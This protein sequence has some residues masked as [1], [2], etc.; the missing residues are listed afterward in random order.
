MHRYRR[1]T[2]LTILCIIAVFTLSC[3]GGNKKTVEKEQ[4]IVTKGGEDY[5]KVPNPLYSVWRGQ[6]EYVYV[7]KS[8]YSPLLGERLTGEDVRVKQRYLESKIARL[9][10]E[11][12]SGQ[13]VGGGGG[14]AIPA[15]R[16]MKKTVVLLPLEDQTGSLTKERKTIFFQAISADLAKSKQAQMV[17]P[18]VLKTFKEKKWWSK[19]DVDQDML[20]QAGAALGIQAF[21]RTQIKRLNIIRQLNPDGGKESYKVTLSLILTVYDGLS[22]HNIYTNTIEV[23]PEEVSAEKT[24]TEAEDKALKVAANKIAISVTIPLSKLEWFTHIVRVDR[25]K[26]YIQGGRDEGLYVGDLLNVYDKPGKEIFNQLTGEFLGREP[27]R[28]KGRLQLVEFFGVNAAI[29]KPLIGESFK[30]GDFV[31]LAR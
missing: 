8:Q 14:V 29:T 18:T 26:I 6:P 9:E 10:K 31:K 27:G 7:P 22:G 25:K 28:F 21:L 23:L 20:S 1:F 16:I 12:K 3:F 13:Y 11:L 4:E 19:N 17:G 30:V 5:V 24:S 2:T 15:N